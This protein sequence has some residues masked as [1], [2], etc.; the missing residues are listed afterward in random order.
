VAVRHPKKGY[1]SLRS[2]VSDVDGNRLTQTIIRAYQ[3]G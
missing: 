1:A 2:R 3:I